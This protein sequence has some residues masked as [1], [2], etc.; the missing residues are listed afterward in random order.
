V[1]ADPVRAAPRAVYARGQGTGAVIRSVVRPC[2]AEQDLVA[3]SDP[4]VDVPVPVGLAGGGTS[5]SIREPLMR[6]TSS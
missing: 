4:V 2:D 3:A 5:L 6:V 1:C